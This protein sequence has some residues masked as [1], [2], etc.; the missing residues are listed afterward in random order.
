MTSTYDISLTTRTAHRT[1]ADFGVWTGRAASA[2]SAMRAYAQPRT[3]IVDASRN[4]DA[5]AARGAG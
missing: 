3:A 2:G 1:G 4:L 5:L